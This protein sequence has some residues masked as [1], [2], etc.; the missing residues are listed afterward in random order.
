M[1]FLEPAFPGSVSPGASGGVSQFA[2]LIAGIVQLVSE[3]M[4]LCEDVLIPIR[5]L[6]FAASIQKRAPRNRR[7][8][9]RSI[10]FAEIKS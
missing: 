1:A 5:R 7:M 4:I 6:T 8:V 3:K 9:F 2:S 10:F